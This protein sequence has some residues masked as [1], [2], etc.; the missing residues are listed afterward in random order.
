ME[1]DFL[2]LACEKVIFK[3]KKLIYTSTTYKKY[4]F[5]KID[6]KKLTKM[7]SETMLTSTKPIL[8]NQLKTLRS[9]FDGIKRRSCYVNQNIMIYY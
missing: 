7:G 2:P 5:K 3:I 8:I 9:V 4:F 6:L 1:E